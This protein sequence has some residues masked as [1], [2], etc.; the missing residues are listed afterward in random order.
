MNIAL[1]AAVTLLGVTC[2]SFT[3]YYSRE[4]SGL[5]DAMISSAPYIVVGQ[6]C[7]YYLFSNGSSLF[8]AW[9]IFSLAMSAARLVN[10]TLVLEETLHL[11][12]LGMG[13]GLMISAAVCIRQ[14]HH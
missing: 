3:E 7:L 11:G 10:S 1:T 4:S 2:I 5:V 12:W 13:I 9:L 6:I 8:G 14:A